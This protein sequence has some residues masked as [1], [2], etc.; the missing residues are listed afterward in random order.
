LPRIDVVPFESEH[1]YMAT[2]HD[3]GPG[4]PRVVYLK[5]SVERTLERC[6]GVDAGEIHRLAAEMGEAGLR[7]LALARKE[8]PPE[9]YTVAHADVGGGLTF[10]GLQGMIDP[11]RAEAVKAVMA[12]HAAGVRVKMITGD[13]AATA[14]A[15]A[16]QLG[17]GHPDGADGLPR[18]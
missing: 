10:L 3:A 4:N 11:P 9:Q 13:H 14:A 8:L 15:I 2:L 7:V 5:G 18:S 16:A 17:M 12:C 6:A 1:Q